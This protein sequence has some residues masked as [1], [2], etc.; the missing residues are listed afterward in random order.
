MKSVELAAM[1]V[2]GDPGHREVCD[3]LGRAAPGE[4]QK[5]QLVPGSSPEG[6]REPGSQG[7]GGRSL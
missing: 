5:A 1:E 2:P 6:R 7:A 4:R 3:K